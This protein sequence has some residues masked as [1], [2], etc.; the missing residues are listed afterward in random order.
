MI[1]QL[2]SAYQIP[3]S[4]TTPASIFMPA[5]TTIYSA[6]PSAMPSL[7]PLKAAPLLS[8]PTS[9]VGRQYQIKDLHN[10]R[11]KLKDQF[12]QNLRMSQLLMTTSLVM[13]FCLGYYLLASVT[14]AMGAVLAVGSYLWRMSDGSP[15]LP[16]APTSPELAPLSP[17]ADPPVAPLLSPPPK[18]PESL[19]TK[20]ERR[21]KGI[22]IQRGPAALAMSPRDSSPAITTKFGLVNLRK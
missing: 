9:K 4:A 3:V 11:Q 22:F 1:G 21:A 16:P 19:A 2:N 6:M 15:N 18:A 10:Q 13:A 7:M 5:F 8:V 14:L 17:L 12:N 20:M